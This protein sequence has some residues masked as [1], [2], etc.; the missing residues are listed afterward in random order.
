MKNIALLIIFTMMSLSFSG[1]RQTEPREEWAIVIHGGA[2][3]AR[4][5]SPEDRDNYLYLL[6]QALET[7]TKVLEEGAEALD[8][9]TQVVVWLE[10]CPY[11]NAGKGAVITSDG[12][13]E[14]DA[15]LMDGKDLQ[16]GAVAG[17]RDI[18]NPIL[19]ARHVMEDSPH[20]LLIGE[21]ALHLP[22]PWVNHGG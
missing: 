17:V 3:S 10:D 16:A 19:A 14:L 12:I 4:S 5:M 21:G 18:K 15:A 6:G 1:C 11:F 2:G 20:V 8:V 7:G 9:V 22:D 13:H